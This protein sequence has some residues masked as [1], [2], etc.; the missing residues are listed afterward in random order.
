M[1]DPLQ[2]EAQSRWFWANYILTAFSPEGDLEKFSPEILHAVRLP[3]PEDDFEKQTGKLSGTLKSNIRDGSAYGELLRAATFWYARS[4]L[5]YIHIQLLM[6]YRIRIRSLLKKPCTSFPARLIAI[7]EIDSEISKW[8]STFPAVVEID[9]NTGF[10]ETHITIPN[11]F[12]LHIIYH[13]CLCSLHASIVPLFSWS[14][15]TDAFQSA[16]Q[17]SAQIAYEHANSIS[18]LVQR[19]LDGAHELSRTSSFVGY[20]CYSSCAIQIPFLRC[21]NASVRERAQLNVVSNFKMMNY[22]ARFWKFTA[23]LVWMRFLLN[24]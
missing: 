10:D 21:A 22:V 2:I 12:S 4:I 20:A 9:S 16:R 11:L 7:H 13:Q 6:R 1:T 3:C 23:L 17:I 14:A 18:R 5:V 19:I 24:S 15:N 8:R